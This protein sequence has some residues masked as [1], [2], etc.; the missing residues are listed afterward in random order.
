MNKLKKTINLI[1]ATVFIILVKVNVLAGNIQNDKVVTG[2]KKLIQDATK[3][4]G[5]IGALVYVL[6]GIYFFIRKNM[7]EEQ[8]QKMWNKRIATTVICAVG[9]VVISGL[10]NTIVKYYQ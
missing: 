5:I 9:I 4:M 6:F 3:A 10:L 1:I 7:A 8:D 2:T